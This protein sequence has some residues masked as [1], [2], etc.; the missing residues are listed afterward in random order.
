MASAPSTIAFDPPR[1]PAPG[2][3]LP[4]RLGVLRWPGDSSPLEI[5]HDPR[6]AY[7]ETFWL[8]VLGP[9]TTVLL[10]RLAERLDDEP[11]GFE[12]D[13][14][15]L[16]REIGLGSRLSKRGGL[17]RTFERAERFGTVSLHGDVMWVKSGLPTVPKRALRRISPRLA[18]LHGQWSIDPV[19]DGAARRTELVRAAHLARTLLSLGE[20][21]HTTEAQLRAWQFDSAIAWHALQ[22]ADAGDL[23]AIENA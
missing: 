14:V 15:D 9:S 20:S 23:A 4:D 18:R 17:A 21:R 11:D 19:T 22:W 7:V 10:R 6:S 1:P 2:A 3:V 5:V 12:V 16:N 13:P 8:P